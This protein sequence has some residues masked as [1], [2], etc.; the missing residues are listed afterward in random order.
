MQDY[1]ELLKKRDYLKMLRSFTE[2]EQALIKEKYIFGN[3]YNKKA[4][5]SAYSISEKREALK[6]RS[7]PFDRFYFYFEL[8]GQQAIYDHIQTVITDEKT[9]KGYYIWHLNEEKIKWLNYLA[10]EID[11]AHEKRGKYREKGATVRGYQLPHGSEVP[12]LMYDLVRWYNNSDDDQ[13]IHKLALFHLQFES[14]HP[15]YD[16]NGRTG[17]ALLNLELARNGFPLI[18]IKYRHL[19]EYFHSFDEYRLYGKTDTL[20]DLMYIIMMVFLGVRLPAIIF[21]T[22]MELGNAPGLITS[23]L[24]E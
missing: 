4:I 24:L 13:L 14:I 15:F 12:K 20:E 17:R 1:N 16:G 3:T 23:N 10:L 5:T 6:N 9:S 19:E 18:N 7:I 2:E 21:S 11:Y 8:I 22:V